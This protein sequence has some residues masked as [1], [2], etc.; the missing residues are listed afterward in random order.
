MDFSIPEELETIRRSVREFVENEVF[1]REEIIEEE[2]RIPEELIEGARQLGLF[3]TSIPEQYGGLGLNMV[4]KCIV[5]QELGRGHA[6][7]S[8]YLGAHTGIGT[9]G[10][11]MAG[12]GAI[13]EKYLPAMAEGKKIGAFALTEPGAGSDAAALKTSAVKKGDRWILNGVKHF[14]TNGPI[15]DVVTTMAVT[16]P[17]RGARGISAFVVEKEFP[18]F[19]VGKIEKKMGLRGSHTSEIIFEDCEVPEENLLGKENEG[20]ITALKILASGRAGLGARCVG[21]CQ[22]LIELSLRYAKE[23]AQFGKPIIANQAIQWMLADMVTETEAARALTLQTAWKVDR[24]ADIIRDAAMTKL[25]ATEVLGRVADRAVQIHG[26]MGYMKELPIE[27]IYRDARIT[28]IY[29][30]TSEVQR[31]VIAGQLMKKGYN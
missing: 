14:I 9:S 12:S 21:A 30:G 28:R 11:V 8:G 15:A 29:E 5:G 19:K 22:R 24:G 23:R 26:G 13:K 25:F 16:D 17:S 4:G 20:F 2:D 27:R 6:G 1:P 10:L 31:M 18:G 7:F 3:G